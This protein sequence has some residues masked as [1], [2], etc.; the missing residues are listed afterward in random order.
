M[1]FRCSE[2]TVLQYR[3][4]QAVSAGHPR[5]TK[6]RYHLEVHSHSS[7]GRC[8]ETLPVLCEVSVRMWRVKETRRRLPRTVCLS[9]TL[10][11]VGVKNTST[12][13][14]T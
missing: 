11:L 5:E 8:Q 3:T 4:F 12:T 7:R 10:T 13:I 9:Y 1:I 14:L 2:T 6:N